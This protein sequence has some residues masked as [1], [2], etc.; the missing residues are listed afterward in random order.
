M[1]K[2]KKITKLFLIFLILVLG[3]LGGYVYKL[4]SLA[5]EW[6]NLFEQRCLNVNPHLISYKN[7]FLLIADVLNQPEKYGDDMSISGSFQNYIFQLRAYLE[8]ENKWLGNHFS[9]LN[10]WDVQLFMPL[11]MK[12]AA[13]YYHKIYEAYK[14]YAELVIE[15]IDNGA[16]TE[17]IMNK[18]NEAR[19]KKLEYSNLY[20]DS[21]DEILRLRDWRKV[22]I[23]MPLPKGCTKENMYIPET[24]GSINWEGEEKPA[25]SIDWGLS[26]I[27][28]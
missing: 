26:N 11:Y 17:E 6:N 12:K 3:L 8:E 25:P 14:D 24:S 22:I 2:M 9:Y 27:L 23:N 7:S 28:G 13:N 19:I 5:K 16:L 20:N 18:T 1:V 15:T 21:M 10:R 4:H